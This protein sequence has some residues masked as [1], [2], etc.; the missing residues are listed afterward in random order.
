[1]CNKIVSPYFSR[2]FLTEMI[3]EFWFNQIF[4][5]GKKAN[6]NFFV[7]PHR[8]MWDYKLLLYPVW[9]NKLILN[10]NCGLR[11][12]TVKFKVSFYNNAHSIDC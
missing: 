6:Y 9:A 8:V 11:E 5:W 2:L 12:V 4:I 7:I 3:T 10:E 1:M